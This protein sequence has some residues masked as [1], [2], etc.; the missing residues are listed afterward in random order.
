MTPWVLAVLTA[1][2]C[3]YSTSSVTI[4]ITLSAHRLTRYVYQPGAGIGAKGAVVTQGINYD[5]DDDY[6][7][8]LK[9]GRDVDS[10]DL[11]IINLKQPAAGPVMIEPAPIGELNDGFIMLGPLQGAILTWHHTFERFCLHMWYM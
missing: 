3:C 5:V 6:I 4:E 7:K 9:G 2:H 11:C 10:E 8:E 1:A